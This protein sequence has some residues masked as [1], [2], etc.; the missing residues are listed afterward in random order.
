MLAL[1]HID[2]QTHGDTGTHRE[3]HRNAYI[4]IGTYEHRYAQTHRHM[5]ACAHRHTQL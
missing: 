5:R 3:I 4:R 1:I 2:T